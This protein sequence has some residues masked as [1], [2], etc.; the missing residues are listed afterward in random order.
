MSPSHM[1]LRKLLFMYLYK[2]RNRWFYP[3]HKITRQT[4]TMTKFCKTVLL[5]VTLAIFINHSNA[6]FQSASLVSIATLGLL[7]TRCHG[8]MPMLPWLQEQKI[9]RLTEECKRLSM[10][11]NECSRKEDMI[12]QL[13]NEIAD[14]QVI[15]NSFLMW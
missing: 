5:I 9:L 2:C 6:S 4:Q 14:L 7:T 8:S 10:Y 3:F 15:I 1:L 11:E 12:Q 13:R